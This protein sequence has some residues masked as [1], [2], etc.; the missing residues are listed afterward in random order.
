MLHQKRIPHKQ[1][2][3]QLCKW[4][5]S[6]IASESL[7]F[8]RDWIISLQPLICRGVGLSHGFW[9]TGDLDLSIR[10]LHSYKSIAI[11][12]C[13]LQAWNISLE[14]QFTTGGATVYRKSFT[15]SHRIVIHIIPALIAD[16]FIK[17]Q[18]FFVAFLANSYHASPLKDLLFRSLKGAN[19]FNMIDW[20]VH[21][22]NLQAYTWDISFPLLKNPWM[23]S[24]W[25]FRQF[26]IYFCT[27]VLVIPFR[28]FYFYG[29]PY[30]TPFLW[31]GLGW[32]NN[33]IAKGMPERAV[34]L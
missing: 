7:P 18:K 2:H 34:S 32:H 5:I 24:N 20:H 17:I 8:F 9:E 16:T 10:K 33:E 31:F 29:I 25:Y 21:Q 27:V 30:A 28:Y 14:E 26:R 15:P 6:L 19:G 13:H 11:G 23:N 4:S 3:E 1:Q 12:A 22:R